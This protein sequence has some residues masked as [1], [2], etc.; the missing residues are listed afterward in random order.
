MSLDA[1]P[2]PALTTA[3]MDHLVDGHQPR[4]RMAQH[5]VPAPAARGVTEMGNA[6]VSN[7]KSVAAILAATGVPQALIGLWALLAPHDF[8]RDFGPG[9]GWVSALGPYDEHLVRDVGG[10]FLGLGTLLVIAAIRSG[11]ELTLTAVAVWLLFALPHT[12]YHLLNL[13]P[14]E[15]ADAIANAAGLVWTVVGPLLALALA[16]RPRASGS[17]LQASPAAD[18][19]S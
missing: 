18:P 11:R 5:D 8:Y 3:Q 13:D 6:T 1:N 9:G 10:L 4:E 19:R 17:R 16:I 12:V 7:R 14:L 15:T 2:R